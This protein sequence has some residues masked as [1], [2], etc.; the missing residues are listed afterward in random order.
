M[1]VTFHGLESHTPFPCPFAQ[2]INILSMCLQCYQSDDS[3][4]IHQR[5]DESQILFQPWCH[6]YTRKT[7]VDREQCPAARQT[8]QVP[9]AILH[10]WLQHCVAYCTDMNQTM[11]KFF[12]L[13]RIHGVWISEV[14]EE[15]CRRPSRSPIWMYL[16]DFRHPK[17]SRSSSRKHAYIILTP[18]NPTFI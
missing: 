2:L 7:T 17:F 15:E 16:L 10:H 5:T 13:C 9:I 3:R 4:H 12:P 6:L 8:K 18:L 1:H 14:H 11:L